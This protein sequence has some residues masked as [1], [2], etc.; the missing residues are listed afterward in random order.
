MVCNVEVGAQHQGEDDG[1]FYLEIRGSYISQR[2]ACT[3][4]VPSL[5]F[6]LETLYCVRKEERGQRSLSMPRLGRAVPPRLI[7]TNE[8]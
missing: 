5:Y 3:Y 1:F 8:D 7:Y 2:A 4:L 6:A